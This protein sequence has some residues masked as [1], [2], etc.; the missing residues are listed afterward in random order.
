MNP[1]GQP[2]DCSLPHW[3][4]PHSQPFL[5]RSHT[6]CCADMSQMLPSPCTCPIVSPGLQS[7]HVRAAWGSEMLLRHLS[8]QGSEPSLEASEIPTSFFHVN[9]L[10]HMDY[11]GV[12]DLPTY[13]PCKIAWI[14]F[15]SDR[16]S[17]TSNKQTNN[18]NSYEILTPLTYHFSQCPLFAGR[19]EPIRK[20]IYLSK[21]LWTSAFSLLF[22]L[23]L[24]LNGHC[25]IGNIRNWLLKPKLYPRTNS[26]FMLQKISKERS[27]ELFIFS[28]VGW[29]L[30]WSSPWGF[31]LKVNSLTG[32][33]LWNWSTAEQSTASG[34][35]AGDESLE[36]FCKSHLQPHHRSYEV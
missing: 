30:T 34:G 35:K 6:V 29:T 22:F 17:V 16:T 3:G 31:H 36:A 14:P 4:G 8:P 15:F 23:L 1:G 19:L 7:C 26:D 9:Q 12:A 11:L 21:A 27:R 32:W 28:W 18:K 2:R 13:L 24:L 25:S 5:S 33:S 20:D 10:L